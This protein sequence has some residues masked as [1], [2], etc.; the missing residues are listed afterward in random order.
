MQAKFDSSGWR[1]E[2]WTYWGEGHRHQHNSKQL[3]T[4]ITWLQEILTVDNTKQ[5]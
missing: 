2:W 3:W 1:D 5:E 4:K